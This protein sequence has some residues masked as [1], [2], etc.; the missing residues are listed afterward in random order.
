MNSYHILVVDDEVELVDLV[1]KYLK[2]EG[3]R[4][5]VAYDGLEA[6]ELIDQSVDCIVL[7]IMMPKLDGISTCEEIRKYYMTP[8]IFLTAKGDEDDKIF[9]LKTGADDYLVKPF[10]LKELVARIEAVIRRT[11]M[12]QQENNLL[13]AGSVEIDQS[14]RIV[15]VNGEK[16]QLTRKE[17]DLLLFFMQHKGQ[18]L[19][20]EQIHQHVWGIDYEANSLRTVDT[21]VKTL[22]VKLADASSYIQTI[23]GVGYKFEV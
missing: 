5:T 13:Q 7:D 12:F 9:G 17:Y 14:A 11:N 4:V 1:S 8:I 20:R 2:K 15:R 16:I 3:Y 19:N 22:R 21:H 10:S 23:W 6:L 18:V